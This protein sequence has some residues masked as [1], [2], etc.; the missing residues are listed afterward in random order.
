MKILHVA[1]LDIRT[2]VYTLIDA[3]KRIKEWSQAHPD[4]YP[5]MIML[6]IKESG[7]G[8]G[9]TQPLPFSKSELKNLESEILQVFGKDEILKPDDIR[10]NRSTLREAVLQEGWPTLKQVKGKVVFAMDNTSPVR[11][12]YIE[13]AMNLAGRLMFVSVDEN[14]PAAAW[15]KINDPVG[16]FEKI[17]RLVRSGFMVRTRADSG[18]KE[19]RLNDSSKKEKAFASGAQFIS[20]DYPEPD[21]RFSSYQVRFKNNIKVRTNPVNGHPE[22]RG[23]ELE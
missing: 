2:R 7:L 14:H 21:T 3:L 9:Y 22:L 16:E 20:T 19:S 5:I 15:M 23:K 17:Q 4:H 8:E 18:T 11:D 6:E 12:R 10:R 13:D 1:D